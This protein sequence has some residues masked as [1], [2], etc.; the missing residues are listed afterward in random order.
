[1]ERERRLRLFRAAGPSAGRFGSGYAE[2]TEGLEEHKI[3]GQ[4]YAA[5]SAVDKLIIHQHKQQ[6]ITHIQKCAM[7]WI[8]TVSGK[9]CDDYHIND[10]K[11][12]GTH[13]APAYTKRHTRHETRGSV[14]DRGSKGRVQ[15][16]LVQL[17]SI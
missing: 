17:Y 4:A 10:P 6:G 3:G 5:Q 13:F 2:G 12:S 1:M 7:R 8:F 15:K 16:P 9:L 14:S 11:P